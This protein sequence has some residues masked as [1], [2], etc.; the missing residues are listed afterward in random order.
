MLKG[1]LGIIGAIILIAIIVA[2]SIAISE[3]ILRYNIDILNLSC[4]E[5]LPTHILWVIALPVI[6][7]LAL[8]LIGL[9][10]TIGT[11][12]QKPSRV[13]NSINRRCFNFLQILQ[14][15]QRFFIGKILGCKLSTTYPQFFYMDLQLQKMPIIRHFVLSLILW[16]VLILQYERLWDLTNEKL[17]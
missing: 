12:K 6:I 17:Q 16:E 13:F 14:L 2:G 4:W 11:G 3:L 7:F 8:M 9:G 1:F 10:Y 15:K 5:N